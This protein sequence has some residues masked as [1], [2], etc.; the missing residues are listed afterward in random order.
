MAILGIDIGGSGIK[1]APVDLDTGELQQERFRIPTPDPP[2]PDA[3]AG[4]I[5][6]I[7]EHFQYSG[8]TGITFPGIVKNGTIYSAVNLHPDWL[9]V[10]AGE[11]FSHCLGGSPVRVLNDA[12]AA[13]IAEMKFGAGKDRSGV[14]FI[15]TLGTG[16]GSALFVD[17]ELVP[18]TELGHLQIRGK[19]AEHRASDRARK[20]KNLDWSAW[21]EK[22]A[23]FLLELD[24]LF[25]P[26]LV[27]IGGGVSKKAGK[28]LPT[29]QEKV[30]F[31]LESA[32]LENAAGIVGA[33]LAAAKLGSQG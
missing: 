9:K 2:V 25:S 29:V 16:I 19:D 15:V 28:F 30:R 12:D 11:V 22:V 6:E 23:E 26:D 10:N 27:I 3:V 7:A 18:N 8:Q 24:K 5:K 31:P 21:A 4:I 17:G 1:G 13:G 32:R 14:V 33:A 20:E